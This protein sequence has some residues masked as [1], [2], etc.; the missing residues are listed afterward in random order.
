MNYWFLAYQI[1]MIAVFIALAIIDFRTHK[2]PH[3]ITWP[4]LA[5]SVVVNIAV[6]Q[7]VALLVGLAV[8]I[9]AIVGFFIAGKGKGVGAGDV[10]L[11]LLIGAVTGFPVVIPVIG[12]GVLMAGFVWIALRNIKT[13]HADRVRKEAT[14]LAP[15]VCIISVA[16]VAIPVIQSLT[17]R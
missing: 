1:A 13:K 4:A 12:A 11:I 7:W 2:I 5:L 10:W 3:Y 9:V 15:Y 16:A 6:G 14:A 8:A 17:A